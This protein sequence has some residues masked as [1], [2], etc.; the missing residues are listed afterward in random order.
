MAKTLQQNRD[1]ELS[2]DTTDTLDRRIAEKVVRSLGTPDDLLSVQVRRVG[3]DHYRVNV[4]VGKDVSSGRVANSFFLTADGEGN[5][6]KSSPEIVRA[7]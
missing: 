4:F 1:E 6:L 5:I 3:G 2:R 7:Y